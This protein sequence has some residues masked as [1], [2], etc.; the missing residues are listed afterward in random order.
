MSPR[1]D[2]RIQ[3]DLAAIDLEGKPEIWIQ[4]GNGR[5]LEQDLEYICKHVPAREVVL[6][7]EEQDTESLVERLKKKVHYRYTADKLKVINFHPPVANW[8][9]PDNVDVPSDSYTVVEF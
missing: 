4:C 8:L 9:D 3:P 5:N 2:Y 1:V 6:V 7:A